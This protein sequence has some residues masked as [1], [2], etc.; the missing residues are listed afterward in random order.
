[1]N[2]TGLKT[3]HLTDHLPT[4][5]A[6]PSCFNFFPT[7]QKI[8]KFYCQHAFG[9]FAFAATHIPNPMA[10]SKEPNRQR[11]LKVSE[12]LNLNHKFVI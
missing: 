7:A 9:T 8:L 6:N 4:R 2:L 10:K 5:Q 1:M 11:F 12:N 3:Y